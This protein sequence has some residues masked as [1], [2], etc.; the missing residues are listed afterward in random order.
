MHDVTDEP[1][2]L[3]KQANTMDNDYIYHDCRIMKYLTGY[4]TLYDL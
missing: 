1:I 3:L 4:M 2:N